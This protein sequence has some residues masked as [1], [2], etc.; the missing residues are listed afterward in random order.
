MAK[1]THFKIALA[2]AGMSAAEFA[3]RHQVTP[4]AVCR[5][6]SGTMR[7]KRLEKAIDQFIASQF[8]KLQINHQRIAA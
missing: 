3:R 4:A 7:S 6:A 5:A 1:S 8:K 2:S